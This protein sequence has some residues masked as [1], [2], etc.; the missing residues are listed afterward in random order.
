MEEATAKPSRP[1]GRRW[2]NDETVPEEWKDK[3]Q[4]EFPNVDVELEARKFQN[5]WIS[6]SGKDATKVDW[7]KTFENWII[8]EN[9]RTGKAAKPQQKTNKEKLAEY[10]R[11]YD[12]LEKEAGIGRYSEQTPTHKRLGDA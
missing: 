5:Y 8:S 1:K 10:E 7:K 6:K 4:V 3:L 12:R 11:Y 9:Q 2:G